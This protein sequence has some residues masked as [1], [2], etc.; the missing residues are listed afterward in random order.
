AD[1]ASAS[2]QSRY[3]LDGRLQRDRHRF[4]GPLGSELRRQPDAGPEHGPRNLDGGH[5]PEGDEARQ[6]HGNLARHRAADAVELGRQGD[7]GGPEGVLRVFEAPPADRQSR[8]RLRAAQ[9]PAAGSPRAPRESRAEEEIAGQP[10][11]I[12]SASKGSAGS[13]AR[14]SIEAP[15]A[16]SPSSTTRR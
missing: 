9:R 15:A 5:V 14:S 3:A 10:L 1:E 7:R 11:P 16:A 4:R 2:A 13:V 12:T 8:A 6:A